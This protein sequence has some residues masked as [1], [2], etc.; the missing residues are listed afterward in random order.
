[1]SVKKIAFLILLFAATAYAAPGD[2]TVIAPAEFM[3]KKTEF[4]TYS[5]ATQNKLDTKLN[6]TAFRTYTSTARVITD[7]TSSK[8]YKLVIIN[9]EVFKQEQ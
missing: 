7:N 5:A 1:M 6:A 3:V 4:S 8:K 2:K 9:G